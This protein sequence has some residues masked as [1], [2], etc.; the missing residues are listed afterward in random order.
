MVLL[1]QMKDLRR[2]PE[3]PVGLLSRLSAS[4]QSK[5][6]SLEEIAERSKISLFFLKA[7]EAGEFEK[8]PGG[9]YDICYLRQYAAQI[10]FPEAELISFYRASSRTNTESSP[11]R[12]ASR[13]SRFAALVANWLGVHD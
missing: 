11:S 9:I 3:K 4:R 6:V 13:K 1:E 2:K 12:S 8:L 5:G 10:G 7:I